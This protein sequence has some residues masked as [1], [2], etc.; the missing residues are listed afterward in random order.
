MTRPV[1]LMAPLPHGLLAIGYWPEARVELT[2]VDEP[3]RGAAWA[4]EVEE[5]WQELLVQE[6]SLHDAPLAGLRGH[7]V[8]LDRLVLTLSR[9]R[10]RVSVATHRHVLRT[11]ERHGLLG[12]GMGVACAVGMV[13]E[14]GL[15]LG[16]RSQRVF[17]GRGQWHPPA[18]HWEPDVHLDA[19]GRPSPFAAARAEM[20]EELGITAAEL[21]GLALVG[22]QLNP[23][24]CKPELHFTAT[25][26]LSFRELEER[27]R[28][29][30]DAHEIDLLLWLSRDRVADFAAGRLGPPTEI[31]R[32]CVHLHDRLDLFGP[33]QVVAP[34]GGPL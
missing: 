18:G 34:G 33:V 9:S 30:R 26:A 20:F 17:G 14:G 19:H 7:L 28:A 13:V 29:A 32:A 3:D 24:T 12:L 5:A 4:A 15:V 8:V 31:A 22:L 11:V 16:R 21:S 2:W 25:L 23:E 6:P 27:Q 10:Y 1:P